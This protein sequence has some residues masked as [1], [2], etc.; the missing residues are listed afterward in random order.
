MVLEDRAW[1]ESHPQRKLKEEIRVR[2][3]S[4]NSHDETEKSYPGSLE[5]RN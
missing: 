3:E 2:N 1:M 5:K 4:K